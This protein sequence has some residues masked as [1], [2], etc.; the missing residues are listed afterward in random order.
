MVQGRG[1]DKQRRMVEAAALLLIDEGF[2]AI[3]HRRVADAA[4]VPQGSASYYFPTRSSLVATAVRAAE[5]LRGRSAMSRAEALPSRRRSPDDTARE[6]IETFF[7]PHVDER[8][9]T[10]RLD[11][12]LSALR[13]PALAPIMRDA[14]PRLLAALRVVLDRSGFDH[15]DDVDLI[16]YLIDAA[17]LNAAGSGEERVLEFASGV[18]G[19]FLDHDRR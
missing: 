9:V 11:P 7:A 12:M 16:A 15:V 8:V 2:A 6:L 18:V 5:D 3:T 13:D 4:G 1:A 17:L 19:R 10:A 14:R